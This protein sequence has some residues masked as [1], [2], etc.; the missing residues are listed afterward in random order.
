M[1]GHD[2]CTRCWQRAA[3]HPRAQAGRAGPCQITALAADHLLCFSLSVH[4]AGVLEMLATCHG[5]ALL[6]HE[7]VGDPLDQ[8]LFEATGG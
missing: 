3:I 8:K 2:L 6:G 7:L 4:A 1:H 5:L